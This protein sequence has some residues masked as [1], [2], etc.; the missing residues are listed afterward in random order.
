ML[1]RGQRIHEGGHPIRVGNVALET[2]AEGRQQRLDCKLGLLPAKIKL[3]RQQ[4][5]ALT[6]LR[7]SHHVEH[8]GHD[9]TSEKTPPP[10]D[11]LSESRRDGN[12]AQSR[13]VS[14]NL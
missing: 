12:H 7:T 3:P 13:A 14:A 1:G 8:I 11:S 9:W 6:I 10:G 5:E 4:I 2:L